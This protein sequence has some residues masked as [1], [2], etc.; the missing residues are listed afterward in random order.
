MI[1]SYKH[2]YGTYVGLELKKKKKKE[3]RERLIAENLLNR[4]INNNH[5]IP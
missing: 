5:S 1:C 2:L 4:E 3:R